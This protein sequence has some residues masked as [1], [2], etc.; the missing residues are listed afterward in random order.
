M[1][2]LHERQAQTARM[3]AAHRWM[4]NLRIGHRRNR[5]RALCAF[6]RPF[7]ERLIATMWREFLDEVLF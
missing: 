7:V 6:S 5:D 3:F 1:E 4:A 2:G